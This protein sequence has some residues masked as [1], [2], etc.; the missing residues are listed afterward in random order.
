MTNLSDE[1]K[2]RLSN[3]FTWIH[4]DKVPMAMLVLEMVVEQC[5]IDKKRLPPEVIEQFKVWDR[6]HFFERSLAYE[7]S[8]S[9]TIPMWWT[10]G[11]WANLRSID[12]QRGIEYLQLLNTTAP[13]EIAKG[14]G[15]LYGVDGFI[16]ALT[17][18]VHADYTVRG[19]AALQE[20]LCFP[21]WKN[22]IN[23]TIAISVSNELAA[24]LLW[25]PE[26]VALCR[27]ANPL[28]YAVLMP[29]LMPYVPHAHYPLHCDGD[30]EPERVWR[31]WY[32]VRLLHWCHTV[33]K[34]STPAE[35]LDIALRLSS[36]T[37][38]RLQSPL[39]T[40]VKLFLHDYVLHH[41]DCASLYHEADIGLI[42]A[43]DVASWWD[44]YCQVES[45]AEMQVW[46]NG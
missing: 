38:V 27:L 40:D 23:H 20:W 24:K 26:T 5:F 25:T 18:W 17:Q 41:H 29:H 4:A 15:L 35:L 8:V 45:I 22:V 46:F 13:S 3:V 16:D 33:H 9:Q 32:F 7:M 14:W 28:D 2:D 44:H 21:Y 42:S 1:W 12:Y 37:S 36:G 6:D 30:S 11:K 10:E 19:S 39:Q 34:H 43:T 31:K